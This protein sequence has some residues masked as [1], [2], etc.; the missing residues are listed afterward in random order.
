MS[1]SQLDIHRDSLG[2]TRSPCICS[3]SHLIPD[4]REYLADT[5][6]RFDKLQE[7]TSK[8]WVAPFDESALYLD[9]KYMVRC[10]ELSGDF[11]MGDWERELDIFIRTVSELICRRAVRRHAFYTP[12]N[13]RLPHILSAARIIEEVGS[14]PVGWSTGVLDPD[15]PHRPIS[16]APMADL[17]CAASHASSSQAKLQVSSFS[18]FSISRTNRLLIV[19]SQGDSQVSSI[20]SD[21]ATTNWAPALNSYYHATTIDPSNFEARLNLAAV[22]LRMGQHD[23]QGPQS[24]CQSASSLHR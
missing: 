9:V 15:R 7:E 3:L 14:V 10:G 24:V 21:Q 13:D 8:S 22:R 16:F 1:F 23:A 17:D 20:R 12:L 2:Y 11:W 18:T 6:R 4:L 19:A 5:E